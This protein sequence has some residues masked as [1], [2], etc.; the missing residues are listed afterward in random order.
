M[1]STVTTTT[2]IHSEGGETYITD[3]SIRTTPTRIYSSNKSVWDIWLKGEND[4]RH[5][6]SNH[7]VP[8]RDGQILSLL[9]KEGRII[10][11]FNHNTAAKHSLPR[12]GS[13][14]GC[15]VFSVIIVFFAVPYLG[16]FVLYYIKNLFTDFQL[17]YVIPVM[18]WGMEVPACLLTLF[19]V[20]YIHISVERNYLNAEREFLSE[21]QNYRFK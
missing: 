14:C 13:G 20:I 2:S 16:D 8:I 7:A 19:A 1:K 15:T 3:R 21:V 12:G 5:F 9:L 17:Q 10:A 6:Q 11:V 18:A 4:E